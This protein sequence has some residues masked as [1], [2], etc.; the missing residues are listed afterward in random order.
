MSGAATATPQ[1]RSPAP[2]PASASGG[3]VTSLDPNEVFKRIADDRAAA[4]QEAASSL[5]AARAA[6]T[7]MLEAAPQPK[8]TPPAEAWGSIAMAIAALGGLL[9]HTPVT[10]AANA[11]AGTL[12]AYKQGDIAK[13][14]QEYE[15][16]KTAH[17]AAREMVD[18]ELKSYDSAIKRMTT[19][20]AEA[21]AELLAQTAAF[22]NMYANQLLREGKSDEAL[23]V[24][25]GLK[26][27]AGGM[28]AAGDA[29][30]GLH[31]KNVALGEVAKGKIADKEKEL[32][33]P[34]TKGEQAQ[35]Y[36]DVVAQESAAA[37]GLKPSSEA[38]SDVDKLARQAF[39]DENGHEPTDSPDDQAKMAALRTKQRQEAKGVVS[40]EAA[41]FAAQRV[42]AGDERA[43]VGMARNSANITKVTN[44]MVKEAAKIHMSPADLAAKIAEFAGVQQAEKTLGTR[45][46]NMEVPANEVARMAPIA[47]AASEKVDRTKYPT[48][49]AIIIATQRGTGDPEVVQFGLSANSLI[50]SYA[51]FLNPTGIPTD[52]DKARATDI[53]STAWA[54]GQFSAAVNQIELEISAGKASL[55]DTQH[56]LHKIATGNADAALVSPLA[57]KPAATAARAP[58]PEAIAALKAHPEKSDEFDAWYGAGAAKAVL[59]Q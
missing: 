22:K 14:K 30:E 13:A 49:N 11:M 57:P 15:R 24:L 9:T 50:Y 26:V 3:T 52:A 48:L 17:D 28:T 6:E 8:Q 44:A 21:R 10:T 32:G 31:A 37:A 51:K 34:L 41:A 29:F 12:N 55:S 27:K 35:I 38:A 5:E 19:S 16:W 42:L 25:A 40:D 39:V 20:P 7:K 18:L 33:R 2:P 4:K 53:L 1:P 46:V 47:L 36:L 58:S 23:S 59:G 54:K 43:I 45:I 56:E